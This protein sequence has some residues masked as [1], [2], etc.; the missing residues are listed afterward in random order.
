MDQSEITNLDHGC[1]LVRIEI[2][3]ARVHSFPQ[4]VHRKL[5]ECRTAGNKS[6]AVCVS[7]NGQLVAALRH[8]SVCRF[9][10]PVVPKSQNRYAVMERNMRKQWDRL[11]RRRGKHCASFLEKVRLREVFSE[12]VLR[13]PILFGRGGISGQLPGPQTL[14]RD[15]SVRTEIHELS[16]ADE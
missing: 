15:R 6:T 3:S 5:L 8:L 10:A 11:P 12:S 16:R 14:K 1:T 7:V 2:V 13:I 9:P 4:G